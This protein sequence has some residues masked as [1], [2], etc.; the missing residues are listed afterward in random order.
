MFGRNGNFTGNA[1]LGQ[2]VAEHR[3]PL[4]WTRDRFA[5]PLRVIES[6]K[7][8]RGVYAVGKNDYLI[9][10]ILDSWAD[11]K[12]VGWRLTI[13]PGTFSEVSKTF[14]RQAEAKDEAVHIEA[15][16]AR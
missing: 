14:G 16:L 5:F 7:T 12:L 13:N 3:K 10:P 6:R 15:R 4:K 11:D 2:I 8:D 1:L 9:T